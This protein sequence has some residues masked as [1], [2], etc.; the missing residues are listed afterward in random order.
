MFQPNEK[1]QFIVMEYMSLGS[2]SKYLEDNEGAIPEK[3]LS[4]LVLHVARG[5]AYLH[6]S[7][8]L[9]NDLAARN[10][11][12]T[13]NDRGND[14]SLLGK[15]SDFG[16]SFRASE[17]YVYKEKTTVIPGKINSCFNIGCNYSSVEC[18]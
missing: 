8:I 5:M 11:L 1:D 7:E 2:L 3:D 9:H 15:V 17:N 14:G 10:V 12:I 13:K 6:N 4:F 16:L 18:A